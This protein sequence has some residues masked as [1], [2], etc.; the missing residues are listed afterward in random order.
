M[1]NMGEVALYV[2]GKMSTTYAFLG[3]GYGARACARP[4]PARHRSRSGEAGGPAR[5]ASQREFPIL[6]NS[7]VR[8][9]PHSGLRKPELGSSEIPELGSGRANIPIGAKPQVAFS[10]GQRIVER[11]HGRY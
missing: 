10:C 3:L 5:N 4:P 6:R 11:E 2:K 1:E 7:G 8:I 9:C